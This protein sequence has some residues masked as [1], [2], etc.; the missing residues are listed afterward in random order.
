MTSVHSLTPP[1]RFCKHLLGCRRPTDDEKAAWRSPMPQ[2]SSLTDV[3]SA[4]M[5]SRVHGTVRRR[6]NDSLLLIVCDRMRETR[7]LTPILELRSR[8]VPPS[9]PPPFAWLRLMTDYQAVADFCCA[10]STTAYNRRNF[11]LIL[12]FHHHSCTNDPRHH[13]APSRKIDAKLL[14]VGKL[15]ARP[16]PFPSYDQG[17]V[18]T[19]R[20][21]ALRCVA[22]WAIAEDN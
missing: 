12:D 11:T 1:R 18:P 10:I 13:S 7:N 17:V 22:W 19:L 8:K 2:R 3:R 6:Y 9:L 21:V 16:H 20:C 14:P 5:A 4:R 15:H